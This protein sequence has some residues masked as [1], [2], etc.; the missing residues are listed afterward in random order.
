MTILF[1]K[2][3]TQVYYMIC[4][5]MG[6]IR[7]YLILILPVVVSLN[8]Y[9]QD[10]SIISKANDILPDR[11]CSPVGVAWEIIYRG[12]NDGG[13]SVEILFEWDDGDTELVTAIN[14]DPDPA[15]REW[16]AST[17]HTYI[18]DDN[19]N[20]HPLGTLVV[21]G[22]ECTSS[23]QEQIVTV[24]DDDNHN[25]GE[26]Y[27]SPAVWP[28]CFGNGDNARF[29]D[30][31]IFNC[32]PPQENDVPNTDTRWIQ[33]VYGTDI[34]MTGTPVTI[35]G[36]LQAYPY[37][38][39]VITLP[40]PVTGSGEVSEVMNVANDK[41]VGQYFEVTLRYWNF[42]NP[43]DD[44]NIQG[45]PADPVNGDHDPVTNTAIILIVAYPNV[46]IQQIPPLCTTS[47]NF[48]ITA[49]P[50]GGTWS[51]TGIVDAQN[52]TFSP[53]TAGA[54][55]HIIRY[56]Y[57][58]GN[59]CAGWDTA[60][61]AVRLPPP[62]TITPVPPVCINDP[63][64][65][66][67]STYQDGTWS[68]PGITD[69][70]NGIFSPQEA[71]VGKHWVV[72]ET[73]PDA[74]GCVGKDSINIQVF[75][76]PTAKFNT[77]D[78]QF[79]DRKDNNQ[80]SI[81]ILIH[82]GST[83]DLV[84]ENKG[85]ID[86]MNFA[87]T[88]A[89]Q[90]NVDNFAGLN[91][92][93]LIKIIETSTGSACENLLDDT[94]RV[95]VWPGPDTTLII[96]TDGVCSPVIAHFQAVEGYA[97]YHWDY[98]DGRIQSTNNG[99]VIYTYLNSTPD[100]TVFQMKLVI[101]TNNGCVDSVSSNIAVHPSPAA[102]TNTPDSSF[103]AV[104]ELNQTEIGIW[105]EGQSGL[106]DLVW[107]NK[108]VV[109]TITF[110]DT[111]NYIVPVNNEPG[112]NEYRLLKLIQRFENGLCETLLNDLVRVTVFPRPD[113]TLTITNDGI[114]SP[115]ESEIQASYGY[116]SYAW[117]Y[118][119]G[120]LDTTD[121]GHVVHHY[122]NSSVD[123]TTYPLK[124]V[125]ETLNGCID[126]IQRGI[127]VHP[128]PIANFIPHPGKQYWPNTTI[129][130]ENMSSPGSWSYHWDFG[131]ETT[132][133]VKDPGDHTYAEFGE[134]GIEL[135]TYSEFCT[136]TAIKSIVILPPEPIADFAPDTSACPPFTVTF[137][138]N[139][140]YAETYIWDFDDGSFSTKENPTHTFYVSGTYIVKLTAYGLSGEAEFSQPVT[141]YETPQA[142]F[143][144]F[145]SVSED[146][147]QVFKFSNSSLNA[148][149]YIW[150][151]GDGTTSMEEEP[152]HIYGKAGE[153]N[154]TLY[155]WSKDNCP[156][157]TSLDNLLKIS[158]GN[159]YIMF[160]N[161]FRWNRTGPTGGWWNEGEIDNTV[162]H[163]HFINVDE[164]RLIIYSRWGELVYESEE[165]YKGWDGYIDGKKPAIQDA[166]VW[167]AWV[168]YVNGRSEVIIGDVT[169]LH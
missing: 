39:N 139:S 142:L 106:F 114:C 100:D 33:W 145:P 125:I 112:F 40:G 53:A 98:G 132:S 1:L 128:Q 117:D 49:N 35:N 127:T 83:F 56:D 47:D 4:G 19:C 85:I 74:Y 152:Y 12:V 2:N 34:T 122:T 135:I 101:V 111:G 28:I 123:V 29:T 168:T 71:G 22:V 155:V 76:V 54:G 124:L 169:F 131:D 72:Y 45:P 15:V 17:T 21:N 99:D 70:I 52:G 36:N 157:T 134:Y 37:Y 48:N 133:T 25:G 126:S 153:F 121:Y 146:V 167:K 137:R 64:F 141:V 90:V 13:E 97:A 60:I 103:C 3:V 42:C 8:T 67:V 156:D 119:D 148:T 108:G 30:E 95:T 80:T 51:G 68:G 78:T 23:E 154:I 164:Y 138:N 43:Y 144:V 91:E 107:E 96:E 113:T 32:V 84:W 5:Q 20:Y 116:L 89:Y 77:P 9:S 27:I 165:L 62:V 65:Q 143:N 151:F 31:T 41:L 150:D 66:L 86:T 129:S 140:I 158:A 94:V 38:G 63:P 159:G 110:P 102:G 75:D 88:G 130:L 81:E 162:F 6:R 118:G 58:D 18:S 24:W 55:N 120:I 92:Y 161:V 163:P 105:I 87:D 166:Y 7:T 73:Q 149:K 109:D 10:C 26:V 57:V 46:R 147:N 50:E 61:V 14:S 16:R 59:G 44:P 104:D 136:D 93:R 11:L 69:N 82:N 160:P 79:C 115:V